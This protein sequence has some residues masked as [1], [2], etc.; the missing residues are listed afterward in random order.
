MTI[1]AAHGRKPVNIHLEHLVLHL[2][3]DPVFKHLSLLL[4]VYVIL[5]MQTGCEML[6]PPRNAGKGREYLPHSTSCP[7]PAAYSHVDYSGQVCFGRKHVFHPYGIF[8]VWRV[9][10]AAVSS[11]NSMSVLAVEDRKWIWY[12]FYLS[13]LGT[14]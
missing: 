11:L 9:G 8:R 4:L 6:R 5:V 3:L 2:P 14:S 1:E 13:H 7:T 12:T 10:A